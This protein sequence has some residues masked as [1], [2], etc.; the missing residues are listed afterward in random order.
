MS[1]GPPS[2]KDKKPCPIFFTCIFFSAGIVCRSPGGPR[3]LPQS[4]GSSVSLFR[5]FRTL[6]ELTPGIPFNFFVFFPPPHLIYE[7]GAVGAPDLS[8][9]SR[10]RKFNWEVGVYWEHFAGRK[11]SMNVDRTSFFFFFVQ[12]S[13]NHVGSSCRSCF[14]CVFFCVCLL[15]ISFL[16]KTSTL[17]ARCSSPGDVSISPPPYSTPPVHSCRCFSPRFL[18]FFSPRS[19]PPPY[20]KLSFG[21]PMTPPL[22][23]EPKG[24]RAFFPLLPLSF[25]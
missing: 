12:F 21:A 11:F 16:L 5:V 23:G 6:W 14:F 17:K 9:Q 13:S 15:S 2:T 4:E 1:V 8:T 7:N 20:E 10:E 18:F 24:Q 19:I 22:R 3:F 25:F